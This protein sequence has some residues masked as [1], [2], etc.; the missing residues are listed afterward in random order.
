MSQIASLTDAKAIYDAYIRLRDAPNAHYAKL[1]SF[2]FDAA[3]VL[4]KRTPKQLGFRALSSLAELEFD[5]PQPLR[6]VLMNL[7]EK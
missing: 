4:L 2:Y 1:S 6:C 5:D 7:S 3:N